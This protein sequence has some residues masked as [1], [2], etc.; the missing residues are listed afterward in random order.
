MTLS[1]GPI[2]E[3]KKNNA[4]VLNKKAH[5]VRKMVDKLI[6]M[7]RRVVLVIPPYGKQR[8]EVFQQWRDI[9]LAHTN[10]LQLPT[11]RTLDLYNLM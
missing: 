8:R 10:D 6:S 4:S 3:V 2:A 9:V 1:E 11:F 5:L 7:D